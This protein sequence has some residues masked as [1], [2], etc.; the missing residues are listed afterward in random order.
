MGQCSLHWLSSPTTAVSVD[1][2][3]GAPLTFSA[4]HTFT[5]LARLLIIS[6]GDNW[7]G[8]GH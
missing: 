6:I 8:D 4:L 2:H 1:L 7:R 5:A 3:V